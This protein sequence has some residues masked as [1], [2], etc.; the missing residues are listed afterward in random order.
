VAE[1]VIKEPLS[2]H[3][4]VRNRRVCRVDM[5]VISNFVGPL[6]CSL[7]IAFHLLLRCVHSVD[8]SREEVMSQWCCHLI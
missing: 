1:D 7:F 2:L 5:L 6:Y 4:F 8:S 3:M